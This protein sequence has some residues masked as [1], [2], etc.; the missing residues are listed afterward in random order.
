LFTLKGPFLFALIF[1][2]SMA[3]LSAPGKEP[4]QTASGQGISQP[5]LIEQANVSAASM[6]AAPYRADPAAIKLSNGTWL[7]AY[8]Q[9]APN[10]MVRRNPGSLE[11][12]AW[13]EPT[14]VENGAISP[15]LV[16]TADGVGLFYLKSDGSHWQAWV[17][18]SSDGGETW[19]TPSSITSETTDIYQIQ[20]TNNGGQVYLFWSLADG[21]LF[22]CTGGP[23]GWSGKS[24]VGRKVGVLQ[25]QTTPAFD[26]K[27][28]SGGGWGLAYLD[29]SKNNEFGT[30]NNP[31]YPV[32]KFTS[33][34]L[35]AWSEPLELTK[36]Y[37]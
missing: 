29:V 10:L 6:H 22:Y 15:T 37:S 32:I 23:G 28:L 27:P 19:G 24:Q 25:S 13:Q 18:W 36:P 9:S 33:G 31:G 21:S 2:L 7:M 12:P 14:L 8:L 1:G 30:A 20:A 4:L 11:E 3:T 17:R 5:P 16:Q 26:I 34:G 35:Q